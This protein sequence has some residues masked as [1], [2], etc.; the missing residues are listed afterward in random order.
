MLKFVKKL[1]KNC[2]KKF[3]YK[4]KNIKLKIFG[5]F[6][7]FSVLGTTRFYTQPPQTQS[8]HFSNPHKNTKNVKICDKSM[9]TGKI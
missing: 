9:I 8:V 7:K 5:K 6:E 4:K 3:R 2:E 1:K